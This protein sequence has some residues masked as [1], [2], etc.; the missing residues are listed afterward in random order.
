MVSSPYWTNA[1]AAR[2]LRT[3][4]DALNLRRR[5]GEFCEGVHFRQ[6]TGPRRGPGRRVFLWFPEA[7]RRHVEEMPD[8]EQGTVAPAIPLASSSLGGLR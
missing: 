2:F 5:H 6:T 8:E 3:S 1:E 7:L 4:V